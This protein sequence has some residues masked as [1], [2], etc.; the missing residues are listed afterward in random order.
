MESKHDSSRTPKENVSRAFDFGCSAEPK[1]TPRVLSLLKSLRNE[2][3]NFLN[4][5]V[6]VI[7]KTTITSRREEIR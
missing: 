6:K 5:H 2:R 1:R 3:T 4:R 7:K